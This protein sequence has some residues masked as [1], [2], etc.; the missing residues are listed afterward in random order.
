MTNAGKRCKHIYFMKGHGYRLAGLIERTN[1][2]EVAIEPWM[3][4]D[5]NFQEIVLFQDSR[6]FDLIFLCV[7]IYKFI[8][9]DIK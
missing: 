9:K 7:G 1:K 5:S 2:S 4:P 3:F 8:T 6:P